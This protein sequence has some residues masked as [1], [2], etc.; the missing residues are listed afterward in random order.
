MYSLH[1]G[2]NNEKLNFLFR[3]QLSK[4]SFLNVQTLPDYPIQ[5]GSD[6]ILSFFVNINNGSVILKHILGTIFIKQQETILTIESTVQDQRE[7]LAPGGREN[8]TDQQRRN[9]VPLSLMN[10]MLEEVSLYCEL[11]MFN[12]ACCFINCFQ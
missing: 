8:L 1:L 2:R 6:A 12:V 11:G 3:N 9:E 10:F 7:I 4:I 5:N